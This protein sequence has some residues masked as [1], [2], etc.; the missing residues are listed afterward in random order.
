MALLNIE[1]LNSREIE[2]KQI[3]DDIICTA[4]AIRK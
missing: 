3:K 4:A 2:N 1:D